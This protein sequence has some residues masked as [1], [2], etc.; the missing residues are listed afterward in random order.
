[1]QFLTAKEEKELFDI[2]QRRMEER[3]KELIKQVEN[4]IYSSDCTFFQPQKELLNS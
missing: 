3:V 2:M 4:E 1:V